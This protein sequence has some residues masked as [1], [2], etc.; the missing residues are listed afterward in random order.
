MHTPGV[1]PFVPSDQR[2]PP[3]TEIRARVVCHHTFG[4]GLWL[5]D[6]DEFAH[7]DVPFI[8]PGRIRGPQ[9]YPP[10]GSQVVGTVVRYAND[11]LRVKL[12]DPY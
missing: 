8:V 12:F 11:Q 10:I 1:A 9:D 2:L 5:V 6:R 3:L 4:I 7:V